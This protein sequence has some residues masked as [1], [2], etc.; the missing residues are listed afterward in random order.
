[1]A[2]KVKPA[3]FGH[4]QV[5]DHQIN[6]YSFKDLKRLGDTRRCEDLVSLRCEVPFDHFQGAGAIVHDENAIFLRQR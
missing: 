1:M 5:G 4:L 6:L 3:D 2:D